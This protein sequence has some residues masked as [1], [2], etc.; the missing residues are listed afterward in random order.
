MSRLVVALA[1]AFALTFA[2]TGAPQQPA[3]FAGRG[4]LV[5]SCSG[6]PQKPS[7]PSLYIVKANGTGF[8]RIETPRLS[9]YGPRWSPNGRRISLSSR[10]T[11]IWTIDPAGN[12]ARRLTHACPECDYPPAAWSPDGKRLVFARRSL[13]FTMNA[14]GTR[15]RRLVGRGRPG[16]GEPDW[17]PD[18]KK[19]AF[20]QNGNRLWVVRADGRAPRKLRR[21]SGR[22]PRWSPSGRWIAFIGF[23]GDAAALM[24]VRAD[25]THPRILYKQENLEINSSPAW[26][27]DGRHIAFAIRHEFRQDGWRYDGH[28]LMVSTL[29]GAQ[30]RPIVIP[31]L[32][33]SA[34]SELYGLDW[35]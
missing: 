30:P 8:R 24:V 33:P 31:E 2:P 9:P 34:Y 11:D 25:G 26:S 1:F 35:T 23:T 17:S 6:C 10:F 32:P 18:G 16:F 27:P 20:D 29:D 14:D 12:S 4:T 5:F 15:Q 3:P 19:I 28:E 13:L 22:Y 7:G 21:V